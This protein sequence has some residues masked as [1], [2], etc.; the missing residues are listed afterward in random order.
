MKKQRWSVIIAAA[1][2]LVLL[3]LS[4]IAA[5]ADDGQE[6]GARPG[7]T[8][9]GALAIVAPRVTMVNQ[10]TQMRSSSGQ[11]RSRSRAPVSGQSHGN[12]QTHTRSKH[13]P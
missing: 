13:L 4:P 8:L 1:M 11:P 7:I 5:L 6:S 2:A 9:Q 10:M 3:A 12:R